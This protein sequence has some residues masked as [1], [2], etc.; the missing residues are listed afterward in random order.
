[1]IALSIG[2]I[3]IRPT[4]QYYRENFALYLGMAIYGREKVC[5]LTEDGTMYF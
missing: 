1:M 2:Y 3:C 4:C 5:T